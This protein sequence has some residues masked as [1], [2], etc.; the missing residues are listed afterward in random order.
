MPTLDQIPEELRLNYFMGDIVISDSFAEHEARVLW[1]TLQTAE[2]VRG[3]RPE[4]F[5]RLLPRLQEAFVSPRVPKDLREIAVSLL[6]TTRTWHSY[7]R[8][9]VHDLLTMGWGRGDD[10]HSALGKRPPRPMR[11]IV[12]C[13]EELRTSGYRLRGLCIITPYWIGGTGDGWDD[14]EGLRSWTRVAMGHI[15]DVPRSV[16]GTEGPAPEPPGGWDAIVAA[17]NTQREA[18]VARLDDC[19]IATDQGDKG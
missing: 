13:A 9:L 17:A 5:G 10:V 7:R 2:L 12:Q 3:K 14:A 1:N 11:E 15:A 19:Q 6:E 16:L 8:D 18:D 4:M